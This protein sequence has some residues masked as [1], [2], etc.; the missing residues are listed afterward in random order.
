MITSNAE[1]NLE[2]VLAHLSGFD[3]V[4]VCDMHSTDKTR[5]IAAS[6]GCRIVNHEHVPFKEA[7]LDFAIRRAQG[8]WVLVIDPDEIVP[9]ALGAY[10]RNFIANPGELAGLYIPRKNYL[11]NYFRKASYPDYKLR[12]FRKSVTKW[13]RVVNS[14]PEVA[15]KVGK[16]P[17]SRRELALIHIP[18]DVEENLRRI[19]RFSSFEAQR[20]A[21]EKVSL[22][23][24]L[25]K[26]WGTF[27]YFYLLRGGFT[28]GVP[29]YVASL[30]RALRQHFRLAKIYEARV[31][32]RFDIS[33]E[34][35]CP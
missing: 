34:E 15:G 1:E 21:L 11:M 23:K 17:A 5:E 2:D 18:V 4:L 27:F 10:L 13:P 31:M 20:D 30:N 25:F 33:H 14:N 24:L 22:L 12:F 29:G 16:V 7:A 26:P 8:E 6:H 19:N 3:E 28:C 32:D 9:R 35:K